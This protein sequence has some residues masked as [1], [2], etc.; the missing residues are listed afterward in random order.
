LSWMKLFWRTCRYHLSSPVKWYVW[1]WTGHIFSYLNS[2]AMT[3]IIM[4]QLDLNIPNSS[5]RHV[6]DYQ[7]S[8]STL[9]WRDRMLEMPSQFSC[10]ESNGMGMG[11]ITLLSA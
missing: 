4:T 9:I 8:K 11:H 10:V 5:I 1:F 6:R 7:S 3:M 2:K